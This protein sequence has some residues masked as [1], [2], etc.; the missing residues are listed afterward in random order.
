MSR[1]PRITP[2]ER[3]ALRL[4]AWGGGPGAAGYLDGYDVLAP[5]VLDDPAAQTAYDDGYAWGQL[6]RR[7]EL[8]REREGGQ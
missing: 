1:K 7:G 4:A 8:T 6:L 2:T 5:L 3:R